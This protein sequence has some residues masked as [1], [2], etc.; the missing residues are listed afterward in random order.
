MNEELYMKIEQFKNLILFVSLAFLFNL[1]SCKSETKIDPNKENYQEISE[2]I[3]EG[4]T[5][6][7]LEQNNSNEIK[8]KVYFPINIINPTRQGFFVDFTFE[9]DGKLVKFSDYIKN[10][11]VLLNFW[12]TWCLPCRRE[13]PDLVEIDKESRGKDFVV[14]GIVLERDIQ[15]A[16]KIVKEFAKKNG[17]E[18]LNIIDKDQSIARTYGGISAVPT[19]YIINKSGKIVETLI[20]MRS[21]QDFLEAIKRAK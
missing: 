15:N 16:E 4:S 12:G 21:K 18:Y 5:N 14:V 1:V 10:K 3:S 9:K 6:A 8:P 17:I 19:T 13:I 11:T 20:G 7:Y 2:L